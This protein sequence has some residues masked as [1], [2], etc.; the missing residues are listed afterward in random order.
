V[1]PPG[2]PEM[3]AATRDELIVS[4]RRRGWTYEKIGRAVGMSEKSVGNALLRIA[5]GRLRK[6]PRT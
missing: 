3:N 5:E 1:V 4:L 6:P 2:T